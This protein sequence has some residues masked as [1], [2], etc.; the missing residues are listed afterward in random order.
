MSDAHDEREDPTRDPYDD[1][2]T[3]EAEGGARRHARGRLDGLIPEIVRRALAQGAGA[4]ADEKAREHLVAEVIRKAIL[5]GGEVVDSTEDGVRRL[6]GEIPVPKEVVDRLTAR[7]DDYK[8]EL[9]RIVRQE[10][11]EF[12]ERVDLGYELQK[13]LTSLSFEI[14]TEIRFVPNDKSVSRRGGSGVRPD[15]KSDV[16]VKRSDRAARRGRR[17]EDGADEAE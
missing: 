7:L 5:K 4:L 2:P 12:F 17:T 3:F 6:L 9:F 13:M 8:A 1:D 10:V 16:K 11:H 14:T 15:V